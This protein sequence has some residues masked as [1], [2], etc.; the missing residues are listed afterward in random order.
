VA[1]YPA[2]AGAE[3]DIFEVSCSNYHEIEKEHFAYWCDESGAP[4]KS[5]TPLGEQKD[6]GTGSRHQD[7]VDRTGQR[8]GGWGQPGEGNDGQSGQTRGRGSGS[9]A[10]SD[11]GSANSKKR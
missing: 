3:K 4:T 9:G 8:G 2:S 5:S 1:P 10:M 6:D 11:A 7:S